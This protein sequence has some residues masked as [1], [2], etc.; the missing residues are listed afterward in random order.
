MTNAE[1]IEYYKNLLIV[2]YNGKERASAHIEAL[3]TVIM[4]FELIEDVQNGFNIDTA[5]GAQQNILGKYL[6]LKREAL[7]L[8]DA[9]YKTYLRY[10]IIQ[11]R[12]NASVKEIDDLL[13]Q[14]FGTTVTA[15]DHKIMYMSYVLFDFAYEFARALLDNGLLPKPAGV[16]IAEVVVSTDRPFA[17]AGGSRGAGFGAIG[18]TPQGGE[19]SGIVTKT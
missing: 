14:F 17:F 9:D 7:G 18:G 16:G 2:Q 5:V 4:I 1:L 6:G 8:S 19:F 12:T 15:Y 3:I 11:N 10:K 13:F